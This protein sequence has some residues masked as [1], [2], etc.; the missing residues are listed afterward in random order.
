MFFRFP[1]TRIHSFEFPI[2]SFFAPAS[3]MSFLVGDACARPTLRQP[4]PN[5]ETVSPFH[6]SWVP[7][8]IWMNPCWR[9]NSSKVGFSDSADFSPSLSW[10]L[11]STSANVAP[12][13][14]G[15]RLFALFLTFFSTLSSDFSSKCPA[16]TNLRSRFLATWVM[17][18]HSL[19]PP[20]C[21]V[22]LDLS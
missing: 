17:R 9:Q 12:N 3:T 14:L 11:A 20:H 21:V 8:F 16:L 18:L 5:A 15:L 22:T 19:Y 6:S 2:C 7:T 1:F 4:N 13:F 10:S